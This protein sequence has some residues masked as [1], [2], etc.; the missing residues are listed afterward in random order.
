MKTVFKTL[1]FAGALGLVAGCGNGS[2]S[3][4]TAVKQHVEELPSVSVTTVH[5]RP[6]DQTSTY[7]S[8]V[9]AYVK[10]N[11][12]PQTVGRI[13]KINVEVGDFV[14]AGQ[15]VAEID[16]V[17]L[18]QAELQLKNNEIE[19][20]R[21]KGLYDAGGLSK[22][23][24]DA[25]ELAYNVS[26]TTYENLLENTVLRS[27]IDGVITARNYDKGDMFSMGQPIYTVEKIVPVKLYVG[28]SESDYTKIK[29]GDTVEITVD[30]FPGKTFYG[31]V[32]RLNPTI[33]AATH[34]FDVE[35]VVDNNYRS[36][37][38]GM[39]ARVTVKFGTSNNV[40][41]P[42]VAVVKQTGS[43]ERFIYVLNEDG[44]VSY[45]NVKI[46]RRMGAEYEILEGIVDGATIVTSGQARLKDG[47]KVSV[48]K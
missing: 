3:E 37:R 41:V 18:Q 6:V 36:L 34:T 32:N 47:I 14:K 31:K 35:V 2:E 25:I 12:A 1:L 11:I 16:K 27:P 20:Q 44:T 38:P 15:V 43:G 4:K 23:D 7:S 13:Q 8:T 42:D 10:N 33:D 21:L 26:K 5:A 48:D 9:E 40:V 17:N 28:I 19:Y 29:K 30:A 39:Y 46:G 24:L 45:T 22:S